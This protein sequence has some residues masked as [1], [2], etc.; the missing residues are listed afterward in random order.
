MNSLRQTL[1]ITAINLRSIPQ[2]LGSSAVI[3]IGTAGVVAVLTTVLA[4]A[5]GL[6]TAYASAAREDRVIVM[7]SGAHSEEISFLSREDVAAI[8]SA[9][10]LRQTAHGKPAVSAELL[11]QVNMPRRGAVGKGTE[12][13]RGLTPVAAD[14]RPEIRLTAGR[15]FTPGVREIIVGKAAHDQFDHLDLGESARFYGGDW[16]VVGLYES[17]GNVHESEVLTDA[18]TLMSAAHRTAF[19]ATTVT[20][21]S[22]L[23][24]DA[25]NQAL[26]HNPALN[27]E[28]QRETDY[29]GQRSEQAGKLVEIVATTVAAIMAIGALFGALNVMYST[30]S[31]RAAEIATMRAIGF[32]AAP[33]VAAVLIE[34]QLLALIGGVLGAAI[35]W[36]AF[37]GEAFN[38]GGVFGQ[39]AGHLHINATLI[40]AGMAWAAVIGFF[41]GLFPAIHS[42][43]MSVAD[44][45]RVG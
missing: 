40:A 23:E 44:A 43:R 28:V 5:T 29:Y 15:M 9:P 25:F 36:I 31:T 11:L 3:C 22:P 13:V 45:L 26:L 21:E 4:M 34:A 24:V 33:V 27:V 14:V 6:R 37:N 12:T 38:S 1:E 20:L 10:G 2:R 16:I 7:S 19:S 8:E 42:A 35:A 17:G 39:V 18:E 41:G 32:G 30:V